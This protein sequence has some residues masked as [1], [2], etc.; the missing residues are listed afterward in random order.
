MEMNDCAKKQNKEKMVIVNVNSKWIKILILHLMHINSPQQFVAITHI[1][2][3][4]SIAIYFQ[5][6]HLQTPNAV[7][8]NKN[9]K[10]VKK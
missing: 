10:S 5:L 8:I 3:A 1:V 9:L 2:V 4:D 7:E 6:V